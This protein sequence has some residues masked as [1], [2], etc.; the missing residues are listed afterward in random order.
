M[1]GNDTLHFAPCLLSQTSEAT[2]SEESNNGRSPRT[3]H[4]PSC[5][6]QHSVSLRQAAKQLSRLRLDWK[7]SSLPSNFMIF[8]KDT[9][10]SADLE[11]TLWPMVRWLSKEMGTVYLEGRWKSVAPT[12]LICSSSIHWVE[13]LTVPE[14]IDLIISIGGDGTL[15]NAAWHFQTIVPPIIPFHFGTV[16]FLNLFN[17]HHFKV[18]LGQ[19]FQSGC[20]VNIRMRLQCTLIRPGQPNATYQILNEMVV[21]R[22]VSSFMAQ[23]DLLADGH[24]LTTAQA[25]GLIVATPTGSTAY[26]LSAG[27]SVVHPEVPAMLVTPIC[28]HTL[29]FR[30]FLLPDSVELTLQI[31][32][33]SRTTAWVAFDGRER[34][35]IKE[36][37]QLRVQ[38]SNYPVPTVCKEDQSRDW[39]KG[40]A[41]CLH[42]NY[43]PNPRNLQECMNDD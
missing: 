43:K 6:A 23:L 29:S 36:G 18:A 2:S 19:I 27:G 32:A 16:G 34:V 28:P 40:L 1:E 9:H 31:A 3:P 41:Q 33:S 11:V 4:P 37:D 10:K 17:I 25:D 12:D 38:C 22:G 7:S 5:M 15:L 39:F 20:R 24:Y 8:H 30:P 42:W 21:D 35:E 14:L 13:N 26:S